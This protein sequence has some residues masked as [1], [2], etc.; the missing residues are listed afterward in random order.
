MDAQGDSREQWEDETKMK[1]KTKTKTK[2]IRE[3]EREK[4]EVVRRRRNQ[5]YC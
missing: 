5:R 3:W 2:T 4:R 1:T